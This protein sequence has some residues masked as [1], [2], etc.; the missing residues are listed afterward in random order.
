MHQGLKDLL[1]SERG[2]IC[3]LL[4]VASTILVLAGKLDINAW[5]TF[6][7]WIATVLVASKTV[8]GA[9]ET[10]TGSNIPDAGHSTTTP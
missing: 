9:V 8:T 5:V 6:S 10:W 3:I 1:S 7:K 2:T 4:I